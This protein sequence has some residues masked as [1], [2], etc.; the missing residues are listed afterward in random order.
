MFK[1]DELKA[2]VR[3]RLTAAAEEIFNIFEKTLKEYE[4]TVFRSKQQQEQQRGLCREKAPLQ[5]CLQEHDTPSEPV[6]EGLEPGNIK[7]EH[8]DELWAAEEGENKESSDIKD[9]LN[10]IYVPQSG[11]DGRQTS[12]QNQDFQMKGNCF[13]SSEQLKSEHGRDGRDVSQTTTDCQASG[14]CESEWRDC[15]DTGGNGD[16]QLQDGKTSDRMY[17]CST[18]NKTFRIKSVLTRHMKTHTGEKPYSCSLCGKHFIQRSYLQTHMNSHYGQKP[19]T[20]RFC[21]R[22]F[23]QVGNMNAH[24]RIH[25][26]EKPHS[27]TYC[28]KRFREKADLIKH[29]MIHTGEKPYVCTVCNMKFTAQ[30]N[31][32][33]HM[34]THSGEKPFSCASCGKR[35]IRN[36]HLTSHMKTHAAGHA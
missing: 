3:E 18:C 6:E 30:S 33:R 14:V 1:T 36:S 7:E 2:L 19:Y 9:L 10:I 15:G 32:T 35:F 34:K 4:E 17:T 12:H 27:C 28:G 31:L 29:H 21:G 24:I 16:K 20:C 11:N 23:S 13:S 25:T 26:G 5:L 22:G 8:E